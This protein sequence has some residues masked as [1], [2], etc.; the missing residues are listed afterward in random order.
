ME[1]GPL[2]PVGMGAPVDLPST[3]PDG[4]PIIRQIVTA[5]RRLNESEL[6]GQN[7]DLMFVRD[8]DTQQPV[9][10]ILEL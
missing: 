1:I 10:Q 4:L 5:V 7:R 8:P 6:L 3:V 2:N 9:I